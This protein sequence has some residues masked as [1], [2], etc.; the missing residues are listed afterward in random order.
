MSDNFRPDYYDEIEKSMDAYAH[1]HT[2]IDVLHRMAHDGFVFH[3]SGKV[4]GMIAD[5]VDDFLLVTPALTFPHFQR[6][7]ITAGEGDIDLVVYE[8]VTTSADGAAV[9]INNTNRSSANTPSTVLTT[10]PTVTD[11]G[12]LI[13]TQWIPPSA[14]GVGQSPAGVVGE[15]NG[16]EWILKPS[17]KYLIRMTNNS[18]ATIAYRY[19][20]LWYEIGYDT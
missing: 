2:F 12:T 5:N 6:L 11:V 20:M 16:E 8:G 7:Q 3:A 19:E 17:T 10:A 14:T 1:A 18:G 13:H 4:T 9:T 15:T